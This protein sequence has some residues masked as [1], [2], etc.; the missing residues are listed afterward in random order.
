Q[1]RAGQ[2]G[3]QRDL[4]SLERELGDRGSFADAPDIV[5]GDVQPA[6]PAHRQLDERPR[7]RFLPDVA[8]H[9]HSL[10]P[11]RYD[12]GNER[13]ELCLSPRGYDDPSALRS[14]QEGRRTP[15]TGARS[16]NN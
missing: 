9:R 13:I 8:S 4:P 3:V 10:A 2:I 12:F 6:E 1:K 16:G 15:D 7:V 11:L 14:E 5:E